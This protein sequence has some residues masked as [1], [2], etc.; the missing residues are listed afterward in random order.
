MN[1][2]NVNNDAENTKDKLDKFSVTCELVR[3]SDIIWK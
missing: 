2:V 1:S 3:W